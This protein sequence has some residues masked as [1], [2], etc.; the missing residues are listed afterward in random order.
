[1]TET[2]ATV[3]PTG[4]SLIEQFEFGLDAPI[5]LTWELTNVCK[6]FM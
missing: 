2:L 5:C 3:R 4:G 6:F 1:M